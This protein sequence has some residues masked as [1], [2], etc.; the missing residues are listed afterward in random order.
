VRFYS[1]NGVCGE[2]KER[3]ESYWIEIQGKNSSWSNNV[4][5]TEGVHGGIIFNPRTIIKSECYT[6]CKNETAKSKNK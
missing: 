5:R 6:L 1:K 3:L 4:L 2:M